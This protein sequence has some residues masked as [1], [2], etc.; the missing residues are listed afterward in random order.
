M[1]LRQILFFES[2]CFEGDALIHLGLLF[3]LK[4]A[5]LDALYALVIVLYLLV[6]LPKHLRILLNLFC[7]LIW[8]PFTK[9]LNICAPVSLTHADKLEKVFL[10]PV[11]KSFRQ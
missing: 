1:T 9:L 4:F 6:L 2:L 5:A 10:I 8:Q 7:R 11:T 3:Q